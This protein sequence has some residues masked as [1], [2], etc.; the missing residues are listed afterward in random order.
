MSVNYD[1]AEKKI[2]VNSPVCCDHSTWQEKAYFSGN[3]GLML[4][5]YFFYCFCDEPIPQL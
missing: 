4:L 2:V 5:V 3:E 1:T